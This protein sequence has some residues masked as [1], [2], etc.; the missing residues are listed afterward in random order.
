MLKIKG[1][2]KSMNNNDAEKQ[3]TTFYTVLIFSE[4]VQFFEKRSKH[5]DDS[6]F[7]APINT[8]FNSDSD[9]LCYEHQTKKQFF[10]F[11][12]PKYR[13]TSSREKYFES[14]FHLIKQTARN[15]IK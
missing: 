15:F 13:I 10:Q 1:V 7:R 8:V 6:H 4:D 2:L 12:L 9:L 11:H 14:Y 3:K 5:L